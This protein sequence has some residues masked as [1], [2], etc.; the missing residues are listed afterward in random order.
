MKRNSLLALGFGVL[1][2][3]GLLTPGCGDSGD[4]GKKDASADVKKDSGATGGSR[5]GGTTGSGGA[6]TGG[7]TG[8]GGARTG[9]TTGSGGSGSGGT[10][11]GGTGAGG[12][13][14]SAIDGGLDTGADTRTDVR[15]TDAIDVPIQNPEV[16]NDTRVLLDVGG[17]DGQGIDAPVL[18]TAI[19]ESAV[20][21]APGE[22][23]I[24]TTG[25][26]S[27]EG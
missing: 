10:G 3:V 26:D 13:G 18:D 8:S 21:T 2:G 14:G 5:T 17:I 6:R 27:G 11:A 20:D 7:T 9:G 1:L 25:L 4:S 16:G 22:V 24:D 15:G 12:T 19:D 23:Q